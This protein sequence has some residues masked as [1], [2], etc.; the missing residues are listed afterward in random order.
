MLFQSLLSATCCWNLF[1]RFLQLATSCDCRMPRCFLKSHRGRCAL[2]GVLCQ[3][4]SHCRERALL[5]LLLLGVAAKF[6]NLCLKG[7]ANDLPLPLGRICWYL[8][9][10]GCNVKAKSNRFNQNHTKIQ[11]R[12]ESIYRIILLKSCAATEI[13]NVVEFFLLCSFIITSVLQSLKPRWEGEMRLH[14]LPFGWLS[15]SQTG[16]HHTWFKLQ[17]TPTEV[18]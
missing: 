4:K 13:L 18:G 14:V 10:S 6:P 5:L 7:A 11:K 17:S 1:W 8:C 12:G 9:V 3:Y 16:C 15:Y 2:F